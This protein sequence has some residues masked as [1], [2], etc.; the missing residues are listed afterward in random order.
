VTNGSGTIQDGL[1]YDEQRRVVAELDASNNVLS[2][3]VYG[4]KPSRDH[5]GGPRGCQRSGSRASR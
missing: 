3:F 1:L 5:G 2:T 4:L